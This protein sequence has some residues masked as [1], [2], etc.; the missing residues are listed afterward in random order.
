M[1]SEMDA[2]LSAYGDVFLGGSLLFMAIWLT[3]GA[4]IMKIEGS[5]DGS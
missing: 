3:V 1:G 2:A 4:L 5:E